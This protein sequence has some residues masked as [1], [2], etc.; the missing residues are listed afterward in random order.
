VAAWISFALRHHRALAIDAVGLTICAL[1]AGASVLLQR[2]LARVSDL[3]ARLET[4]HTRLADQIEAESAARAAEPERTLARRRADSVSLLT[5]EERRIAEERRREF[6]ERERE[7]GAS[8]NEAL[9]STQSQ[10][11]QR[12]AGWAQDL[13]RAAEV[14]K[15]RIQELAQHQRSLL[16][17]VE[18]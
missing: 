14:T 15:S 2:A 12:L 4:A 1:G 7:V 16:S 18:L 10:V 8:L 17:E 6:S 5:E 3:D 13:D 9:T 11:E